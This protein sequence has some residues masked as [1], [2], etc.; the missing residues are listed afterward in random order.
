MKKLILML[1]ILLGFNYYAVGQDKTFKPVEIPKDYTTQI[2][3]IYTKINNWE[4]R[5]DIYSNPIS[6]KP[7]PIVINIHGGGWNHGEKESQSGFGSFFKNGYAVANVEYR[8]VDVAPAPAAIEDVRCALIYLFNH[9]IALN[10]DTNK[11]VIMGGSAGGHLAL[12]AGLLGND[13]Q[14]D[15]NCPFE[16]NIKVA[17]IIDKYGVTDLTPLLN[18]KS[19]RNWLGKGFGN[20]GFIESVSPIYYVSEQSPPTFI[21]HGDADPIVPYNQ[22]EMLFEKLKGYGIKTEFITVKGGLHGKFPK[23]E[24]TNFSDKMWVFL[25]GLGL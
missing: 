21:I 13:N 9:A 14:F 24:N 2:D 20:L 22:S 18:W 4:G 8:L 19:A 7:T 5:M 10:I 17:A 11:I 16:G 12:M 15:T 1:T 6:V 23:E 3:V 25:K